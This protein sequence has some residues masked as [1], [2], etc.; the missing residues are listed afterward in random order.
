MMNQTGLPTEIPE[1]STLVYFN[2]YYSSGN[3]VS[4]TQNE[5]DAVVGYFLKRGFERIAAINTG[6]VILEQA[7]R[8]SVPVFQ[9]LDTL[10]GVNDVQLSNLIAQIINANRR[11]TSSIGYKQISENQLFDQRNIVV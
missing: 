3:S 8:D 2:N 9:L 1:E 6:G 10:K 5:V 4:Y 11:K 7:K